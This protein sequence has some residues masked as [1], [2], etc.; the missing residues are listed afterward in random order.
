MSNTLPP[1]T[2]TIERMVTHEGDVKLVIE[3]KK[4]A[5][6]RNGR[7]ADP[8]EPFELAGKKF[9]VTDVYRQTLGEMTDQHAQAEGYENMEAYKNH[10]LSLHEGMPFLPHMRVWVHEFKEVE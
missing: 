2:C 6:R 9:V 7:Y 4:L 10:I 3:G 5:T 1:K 8:G